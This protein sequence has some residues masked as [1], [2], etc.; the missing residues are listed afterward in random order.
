MISVSFHGWVGW[1]IV[2]NKRWKIPGKGRCDDD[3]KDLH[4]YNIYGTVIHL[5]H[6]LS[7]AEITTKE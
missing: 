1:L 2:G 7:E 6:L 3:D 5:R 4:T